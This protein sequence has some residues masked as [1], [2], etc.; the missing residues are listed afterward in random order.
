MYLER[1]VSNAELCEALKM[2]FNAGS[3]K[4]IIISDTKIVDG[5]LIAIL[6]D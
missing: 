6:K 2:F 5:E 1:N 3:P 4:E